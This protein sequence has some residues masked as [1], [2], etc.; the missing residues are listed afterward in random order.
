MLEPLPEALRLVCLETVTAAMSTA[1][2]CLVMMTEMVGMAGA[3]AS[4]LSGVL[5][6]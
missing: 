6:P 3:M 5:E 2:G 4:M 1:A